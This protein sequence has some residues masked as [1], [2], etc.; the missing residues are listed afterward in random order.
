MFTGRQEADSV[1]CGTEGGRSCLVSPAGGNCKKSKDGIVTLLVLA[2]L[3]ETPP[4]L[5]AF[6]AAHSH[7]VLLLQVAMMAMKGGSLGTQLR[8]WRS[9][10]G[11]FLVGRPARVDGHGPAE[12]RRQRARWG[13][14]VLRGVSFEELVLAAEYTQYHCVCD[15]SRTL[16]SRE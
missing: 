2:S 3:P 4:L 11:V 15:F 14:L 10:L 9:R 8:A 16:L 12:R 7:R 5:P 1:K 13:R 6:G